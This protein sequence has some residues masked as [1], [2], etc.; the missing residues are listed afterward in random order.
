MND[1][2][3]KSLRHLKEN[4]VIAC[5]FYYHEQHTTVQKYGVDKID[6]N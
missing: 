6:K 3:I 2:H 5:L 1:Y 4:M